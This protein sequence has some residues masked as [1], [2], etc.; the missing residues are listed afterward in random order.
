M[1]D[2]TKFAAPLRNGQP[3]IKVKW[4]RK[5]PTEGYEFTIRTY[6]VP[7]ASAVLFSC[8]DTV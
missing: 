3:Y 5:I 6:C 2:D 1:N 7:E 8:Y 4:I